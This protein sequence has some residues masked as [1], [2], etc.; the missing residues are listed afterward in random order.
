MKE[1]VGRRYKRMMEEKQSLPQLVIIDGGKGQLNAAVEAVA[2]LGLTGAMTLVGLAKNKEEL[3][4][5]GDKESV[6][7][8]WSDPALLLIRRIRDEVHRFGLAFHRQKRSKAALSNEME[9]IEG[10]GQATMEKLL[11]AFKSVRKISLQSEEA[12]AN[13]IGKAKANLVYAYF[14]NKEPGKIPGSE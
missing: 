11:K 12:L 1:V 7:L 3:F 6:L 9:N 10:I 8:N 13:V 2:E 4:F 5:P 14:K